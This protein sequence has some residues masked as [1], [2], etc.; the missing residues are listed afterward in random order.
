MV[1]KG[2]EMVYDK[3]PRKILN[4]LKL[5][6]TGLPKGVCECNGGHAWRD[7]YICEE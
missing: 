3:V 1:F 4:C 6:K 7:E 5:I 2:L